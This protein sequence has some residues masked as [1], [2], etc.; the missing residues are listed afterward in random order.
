MVKGGSE[1]LLLCT[2]LS[3]AITNTRE[4]MK[5]KVITTTKQKQV[6]VMHLLFVVAL[7]LLQPRFLLGDIFFV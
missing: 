2:L 6:T 1:S 5:I 3:A 4:G 7:S